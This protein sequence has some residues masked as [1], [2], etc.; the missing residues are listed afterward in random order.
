MAL[1]VTEQLLARGWEGRLSVP[2]HVFALFPL[3]HSATLERL[4]RALEQARTCVF[5]CVLPCEALF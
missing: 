4:Q 1:Q 5:V 3:R 2:E